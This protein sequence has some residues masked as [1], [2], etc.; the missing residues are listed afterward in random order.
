MVCLVPALLESSKV[1]LLSNLFMITRAHVCVIII[2]CR[3]FIIP[4]I[5]Y[6]DCL[7]SFSVVILILCCRYYCLLLIISF[8]VIIFVCFCC[9]FCLLLLLFLF[10]WCCSCFYYSFLLLLL[11]FFV[12]SLMNILFC[13]TALL[14]ASTF[15]LQQ[16]ARFIAH[17]L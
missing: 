12:G 14:F 9:Y 10:F 5:A 7:F 11:F 13:I 3:Y 4:F 6:R 2:Y 15:P 16:L 1:A 17:A 8:V